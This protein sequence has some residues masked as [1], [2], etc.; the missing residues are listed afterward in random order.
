MD[1]I[2]PQTLFTFITPAFTK[3]EKA[4]TAREEINAQLHVLLQM[5]KMHKARS[6]LWTAACTPKQER[7]WIESVSQPLTV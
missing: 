3:Q 1:Y 2:L 4:Y 5:L 7:T 6:I